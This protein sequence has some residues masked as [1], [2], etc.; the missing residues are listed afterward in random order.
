MSKFL[1]DSS[2]KLVEFALPALDAFW[3]ETVKSEKPLTP[4]DLEAVS[5]ALVLIETFI[6]L[7]E[8]MFSWIQ[9]R[10]MEDF[11]YQFKTSKFNSKRLQTR[12]CHIYVKSISTQVKK[13]KS[14]RKLHEKIFENI[15]E[16]IESNFL[17]SDN[18]D[19][20]QGLIKNSNK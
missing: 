3:L 11:P 19:K 7:K 16:V 2:S 6:D 4:S 8:E 1:Q 10:I 14:E 9:K 5:N 18:V 15:I 12:I 13:T 20:R 17:G